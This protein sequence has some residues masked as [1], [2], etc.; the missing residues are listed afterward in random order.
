MKFRKLK[1]DEV[2]VQIDVEPDP[3]LPC[4]NEGKH[5][6]DEEDRRASREIRARVAQGDTYAWCRILVTVSWG[7]FEGYDSLGGVSLEDEAD[8][9]QTIECHGM[10]E[11]ALDALQKSMEA[12]YLKL[13]GLLRGN[14]VSR[15]SKPQKRNHEYEDVPHIA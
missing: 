12:T 10:K 13:H 8:L 2:T 6:E 15:K 7:E 4:F 5:A 9:L 11:E 1:L 3:N 14:K